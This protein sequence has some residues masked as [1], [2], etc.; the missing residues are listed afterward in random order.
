MLVSV[1]HIRMGGAERNPSS[2]F[3]AE[4]AEIAEKNVHIQVNE[5]PGN[6]R[7]GI[8]FPCPP[9]STPGAGKW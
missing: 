9:K 1:I 3:I 5:M 8:A 4:I 6:C 2:L 7:V